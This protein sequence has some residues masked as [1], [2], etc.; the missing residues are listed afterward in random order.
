LSI[1]ERDGKLLVHCHAGC[2]QRAVIDALRARGLWPERE[3]PAWTPA[4]KQDWSRH[5]H[6]AECWKHASVIELERL[7]RMACE[8]GDF[9]TLAWA[10]PQLEQTKALCGEQLLEYVA[11]ELRRDAK[12]TKRLIASGRADLRRAEHVCAAIVGLLAVATLIGPEGDC[13]AL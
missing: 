11:A 10:A 13:Y 7:K 8:T 2:D 9:S 3:R 1:T 6:G 4:E 5:M 12:L